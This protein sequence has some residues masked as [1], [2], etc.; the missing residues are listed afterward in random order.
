[1]R[2]GI[3]IEGINTGIKNAGVGIRGVQHVVQW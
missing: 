1:M 2:G 3:I